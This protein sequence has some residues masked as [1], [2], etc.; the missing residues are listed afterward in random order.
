MKVSAAT[1]LCRRTDFFVY[2]TVYTKPNQF[3]CNDFKIF[4]NNKKFNN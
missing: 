4:I 3:Y 1:Y 2:A